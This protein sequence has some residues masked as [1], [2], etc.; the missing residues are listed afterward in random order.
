MPAEAA[1]GLPLRR[2]FLVL[3]LGWA[4][5]IYYLSDQ[6]GIVVTPLL[7]YEDK[8]LHLIAYGVLGFLAMGACRT[9]G[10]RHRAAHYWLVVT[11]VGVYGVLDEVHQYF[12]PGRNSDV[13]D[14]LADVCGG[15]LGAGLMFLLRRRYAPP[16]TPESHSS[17]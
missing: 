12:V 1:P 15:L 5:L 17:S 14:V 7:P 6:P 2:L 8:L 13:L 9:G 11:L 3:T 4:A 10:C 16:A